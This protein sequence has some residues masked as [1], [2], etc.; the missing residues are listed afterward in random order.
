MLYLDQAATSFPKPPQVIEAVC[1]ALE[2][3]GNSGRG[4]HGISLAASRL[5]YEARLELAEFLG[6]PDPSSIALTAN[7]TESLNL[8]LLGFLAPGDHVITTAQEHNSVLRPL[9]L[10]QE[11]GV[12]ITILPADADGVVDF[13]A[14]ASAKKP[15][16]KAVVCTHASNVTGNVIDLDYLLDFCQSERLILILDAAQTAGWYS[17]DLAKQPID[18][19]CFTG[20]KAL[21]GPQGVGGIY[22]RPGLNLRPLKTGGSGIQTFSKTHP[23]AMPEALEAGTLNTPGIAG[24]AAGVRL[25][26]EV[27]LKAIRQKEGELTRF[28]Y[29]EVMNIP[30]ITVY[31]DFSTFERCPIVAL[32]LAGLDSSLVSQLLAEEYDIASRSGG[33]C[34][35]LM[36]RALGTERL[37][38]VRFSFSYFNS[39]TELNRAVEALDEISHEYGADVHG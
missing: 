4:G 39:K 19:L 35:P 28:F 32:N 37:G 11:Q 27:G 33:H 16:T 10:L 31:G 36:H 12:E 2:C 29:E 9:Y 22:V 24:L 17:Y 18:I 20:H 38:A 13:T 25:V 34:A 23:Q 5:V 6:A 3:A 26:R 30:G 21:Y 14:L 8:A 7:A 15:N 1:Q